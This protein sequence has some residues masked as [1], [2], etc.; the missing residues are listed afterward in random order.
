MALQVQ[1]QP[2]YMKLKCITT[3]PRDLAYTVFV[4]NGYLETYSMGIRYEH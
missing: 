3:M 1:T 2:Y 4:D